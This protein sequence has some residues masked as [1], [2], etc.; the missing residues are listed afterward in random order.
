[1]FANHL[2]CSFIFTGVFFIFVSDEF[3]EHG[4]IEYESF[5]SMSI[6]R[7]DETQKGSPILGQSGLG[8]NGN[9]GV[10]YTS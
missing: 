3:F 1:M 8:Y 6:W 4:P 9:E 5:L 10:L 7:I 2:P